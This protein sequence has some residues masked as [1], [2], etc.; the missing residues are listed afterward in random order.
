MSERSA[1]SDWWT[2]R[3]LFDALHSEFHFTLDAA[4]DAENALCTRYIGPPESVPDDYRIERLGR[5]GTCVGEDG[6]KCRWSGE[7]V[8]C[9]PP[10]GGQEGQWVL[11]AYQEVYLYPN[12]ADLVVLLLPVKTGMGWFHAAIW[13]EDVHA[14]RKGVEVRFLKGRQ[15]FEG[16]MNPAG[17]SARFE[18]MVV[19][20]RPVPHVGCPPK[21][22]E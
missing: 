20:M 19:V 21:E 18:S 6:L 1:S 13:R 14:P 8:F 11:K 9:N 12:G 16:P 4:A 10:Y 7:R 22:D 2:P 15:A 17:E 5:M 3:A